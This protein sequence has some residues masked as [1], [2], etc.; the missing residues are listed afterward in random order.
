LFCCG[1]PIAGLIAIGY[2]NARG[3]TDADY[4]ADTFSVV[5]APA[6]TDVLAER[7]GVRVVDRQWTVTG[8]L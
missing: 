5:S 1:V 7:S 6:Y 8:R 4:Q 2:S 3:P